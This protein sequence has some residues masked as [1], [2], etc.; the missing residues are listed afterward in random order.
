MAVRVSALRVGQEYSCYYVGKSISKLQMD[1]ER[2]Q[3]RVLI[4]KILLFLNIIS[5]YIEVFFKS[6]LLFKFYIHL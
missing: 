2:E 4:W 1:I 3:R 5:L 6:V